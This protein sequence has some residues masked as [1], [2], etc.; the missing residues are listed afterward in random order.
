VGDTTRT[1][2]ATLTGHTNAIFDLAFSPDGSLLATASQDTTGRLWN[3]ATHNT[4][5]VLTG[6]TVQ[7][8]S[9]AFSP[10]GKTLASGDWDGTVQLWNLH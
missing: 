1:I 5:A 3:V 2:V 8:S 9:V 4:T 7:V 6:H 10:D